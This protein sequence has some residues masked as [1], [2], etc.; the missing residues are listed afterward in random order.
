MATSAAVKPSPIIR[1]SAADSSTGDL[2]AND[3]AR[4]RMAQ[5]TTISAMNSPSTL[6]SSCAQALRP[7]STRV[8]RVA[9]S[10]MYTGM[11]TSSLTRCRTAEISMLDASSTAVVASPM[12]RP[13]V[14]L[15]VTASVGHSASICANTTLLSQRPSLAMRA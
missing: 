2:E 11:R 4:P 10:T 15:P 7:M 6:Y 8:T 12:P 5:F 9:M 3:S 1:P 14:A 13:L